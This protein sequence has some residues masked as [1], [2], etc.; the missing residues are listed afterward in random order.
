[1]S[2]MTALVH[3]ETVSFILCFV[4]IFV[5]IF[6]IVKIIQT[7][8]ERIFD[9]EIMKGLDRSLGFFFGLVEGLVVI[10]VFVLIL[11]YQPWFD[12]TKIFEGSLFIKLLSPLLDYSSQNLPEI[13]PE[14][15]T[16][17][18]TG[19]MQCLKIL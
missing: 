13:K 6:L 17:F 14:T 11:T 7:V 12:C 8:F 5:V 18:V 2:H 9:G 1:M 4:L 3:N 10:F 16:A 15:A 19:G